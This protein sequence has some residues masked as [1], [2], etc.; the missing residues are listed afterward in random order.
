MCNYGRTPR[1]LVLRQ[2][3][4]DPALV[5]DPAKDAQFKEIAVDEMR[6]R[7]DEVP[8]TSLLLFTRQILCSNYMYMYMYRNG[9]NRYMY[10][11]LIYLL[12]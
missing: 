8:V 6:A 3:V 9:A 12:R 5:A 7:K 2:N 1:D 11:Y 4:S 10:M